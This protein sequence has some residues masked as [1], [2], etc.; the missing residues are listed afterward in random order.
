MRSNAHIPS[1]LWGIL[2]TCNVLELSRIWR[3]G[4]TGAQA[5]QL[6]LYAL[7]WLSAALLQ[8]WKIVRAQPTSLERLRGVKIQPVQIAYGA[9]QLRLAGFKLPTPAP[10]CRLPVRL[11]LTPEQKHA[12][13]IKVVKKRIQEQIYVLTHTVSRYQAHGS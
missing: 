5:V 12:G 11:L 7:H 13:L 10:R 1:P 4:F 8:S 3:Y 6:I 9:R 2:Q